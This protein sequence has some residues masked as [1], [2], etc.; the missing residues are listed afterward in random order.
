M[1]SPFALLLPTS[2]PAC[3]RIGPAPC[4][5]CS[6]RLVRPRP[7]PPPAGLDGAVTLFSYEGPGAELVR[8]LK[9][10]NHRDA[11]VPLGRALAALVPPGADAVTWVPTTAARR[12]SRSFDQA[13]LIAGVV[14]RELGVPVPQL[15]FRVDDRAQT[16]RSRAER[17]SGPVFR[18]GSAP[19]GVVIVDDVRTT[20]ASLSSAAAALRGAG[21]RV[22]VGATLAATPLGAVGALPIRP[23]TPYDRSDEPEQPV[24]G[25]GG[26][27]CRST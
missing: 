7:A 18:A 14:G 12:R 19:V 20:G 13:R 1:V 6:A 16:G 11:L 5:S 26:R 24:R 3:R 8:R 10:S 4:G 15:L 21:A 9:Y 23:S 25:N 17:A 22:V 2:C 27:P